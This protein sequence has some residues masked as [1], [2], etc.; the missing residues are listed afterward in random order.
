MSSN[1]SKNVKWVSRPFSELE[2][3]LQTWIELVCDIHKIPKPERYEGKIPTFISEAKVKLTHTQRNQ[4]SLSKKR[5][6]ASKIKGVSYDYYPV[7]FV[8]GDMNS[9]CHYVH[10]ITHQTFRLSISPSGNVSFS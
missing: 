4:W 10:L 7:G 5:M 2:P 9:R 3:D 6:L 1:E 8:M